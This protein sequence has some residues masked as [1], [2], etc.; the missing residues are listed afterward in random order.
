MLFSGSLAVSYLANAGYILS[1]PGS[2]D[3]RLT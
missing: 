3:P 1:S 2:D